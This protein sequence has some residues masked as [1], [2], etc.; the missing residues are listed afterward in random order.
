MVDSPSQ[1]NPSDLPAPPKGGASDASARLAFYLETAPLLQKAPPSG[2]LANECEPERVQHAESKQVAPPQRRAFAESGAVNAV[3]LYDPICEK[4]I[5]ENPQIFLNCNYKINFPLNMPRDHQGCR[6][7]V[8]RPQPSDP[9][10]VKMFVKAPVP[11]AWEP[12][13]ISGLFP[14]YDYNKRTG[15]LSGAQ[16][17]REGESNLANQEQKSICRE[18]GA[19]TGGDIYI[20]VV[21][22]VRSGKSTF[23][24]RFM[25][26]L[27]LPAIGPAAAR[28]RARDELPQSAAGRTIMTTEPKFIPE[29]AVPL[30]LEGGGECR[31]RLIDCVGYMVEGAMGHEEND[32]PRMVKSPWFDHEVPFDLAAETG[33]RKVICEHSTIGIV[34]TTDGSVSDIPREGYARTEKRIVEELNAL[35]KPYIILLN[36]THPDAPETK[37]LAEGMARDYDHT[38]LPVSCV[39]LDAEA[40][41]SILRQVLYEFPVQELDFALPRWVTMLENGHWL[42]TQVYDAAMQLA[43]KV[44]R[45]KDVPSGTDAPALECDAVQRSAIS[46]IDLANGS[47]RITVELK[48][49]IFYQV[50]S[51]Q[52][53]L[54]IGDEAGLMPCIMELAK[55]KREYEKVRSA[56]E[57]VEATG[58]G[59]VMPTVSELKLEQ[60]QIV[61]Q[62]TNYGVRLEA[63]APSIQM[64][65]ATIHTEISPIVGTEKQ[66]EDLARSLLA[67]FEDDPEKLWESNIFGKS[68]HELVNEGLQNKLLHMPQEART[69]LQETLERVINE[70]CTGLICILI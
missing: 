30:Q 6:V 56:L 66:S 22:P 20:G 46:G 29:T 13:V 32:K 52:T 57:Q 51:E 17:K 16:R 64:M 69:R 9:V 67:G 50:L 34:V 8:P 47:V 62:G 49:E 25:E 53:G 26:Q 21:G 40:L 43:A 12:F 44:S 68:L 3:F 60:P 4:A 19:R 38:V 42:Q 33:T 11:L 59:I 61:R 2:E 1:S 7:P 15:I 54:A 27:V 55:A 63:C 48:P 70:G 14:T 24:K 28:E 35:G 36:S 18:I 37:Q 23:I 58:Y 31:V 41:G 39:D 65:K 45:M 10:I 5:Q